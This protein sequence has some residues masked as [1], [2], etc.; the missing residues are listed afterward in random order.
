MFNMHMNTRDYTTHL[1]IIAHVRKLR[2]GAFKG[3]FSG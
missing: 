2:H 1:V 3:L